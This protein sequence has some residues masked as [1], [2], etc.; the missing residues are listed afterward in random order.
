MGRGIAAMLL[1]L[2]L[3][4][5]AAAQELSID[6]TADLDGTLAADEDVVEDGG[7][8]APAKVS[9]GALPA[10]ADVV[11]YSVAAGGD[12]LFALDVTAELA[13]G[14]VATPRD[15]VRWDGA[16]YAIEFRGADHDV[17]AGARID[18]IGV[19]QGDLLLSFD[20]ALT[21]GDA[22]AADEDLLR[23]ESTQPDLWT[24]YFD[25]SAAGVPAA[26]DLDG[27]DLLDASGNLALSFDVSGEVGGV[28]FADEDILEY[29]PG[30]GT[31]TKRFAGASRF[32]ALAAADVDALFVP[33]PSAA[34][35][36]ALAAG[37]LLTL[38]RRRRAQ[39]AGAALGAHGRGGGAPCA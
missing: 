23:L 7:S 16:N 21:L 20:V 27:A 32:P 6:V 1:A 25:G 13:G 12:V 26:A 9:L 4:G 17:P 28:S 18:A 22:T 31:W 36:A 38:R 29:A 2:A 19:V 11:G 8:G 10:A 37:A 30:G 33:E 3:A 24:L 14:V 15:V 35:L 5:P 39:S 34:A